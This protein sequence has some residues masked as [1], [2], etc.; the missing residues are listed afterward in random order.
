MINIGK[1]QE[2]IDAGQSNPIVLFPEGATTNNTELIHFKRGAFFAL[3]PVKPIT[4]KYSGLFFNPAHDVLNVVAHALFSACQPITYVTVHELPVF[5][6]NDYFFKNH[7]REGEEKWQAYMRVVRELMA[8]SLKFKLSV[9][10]MEDKLEYKKL[11]Y[12]HKEIK[13]KQH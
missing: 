11:L 7:V 13:M 1:R 12:P 9:N 3:Y 6:P 10:K 8:E 2:S 5:T 4:I